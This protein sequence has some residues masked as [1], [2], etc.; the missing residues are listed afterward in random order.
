MPAQRHLSQRPV[1]IVVPASELDH[2]D[3]AG[4]LVPSVMTDLTRPRP[5]PVVDIKIADVRFVRTKRTDCLNRQME[6]SPRQPSPD[7]GLPRRASLHGAYPS[8]RSSG[9][10]QPAS[11]SPRHLSYH[12]IESFCSRKPLVGCRLIPGEQEAATCRPETG[13]GVH[14]ARALGSGG[15]LLDPLICVVGSRSSLDGPNSFI[16]ASSRAS[17]FEIPRVHR[18]STSIR[19]PSSVSAGSYARLSW[20]APPDNVVAVGCM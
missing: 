3:A 1:R 18:R 6:C 4:V 14:S 16:Q 20:I 13:G 19:C 11:A 15:E 7:R 5:S 17:C 12:Q 10:I 9:K 8:F 2:G